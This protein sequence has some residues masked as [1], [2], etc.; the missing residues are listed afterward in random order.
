[1]MLCKHGTF[2]TILII[3]SIFLPLIFNLNAYAQGVAWVQEED[4]SSDK[5]EV[6]A[7]T[8]DDTYIYITGTDG[9]NGEVDQQWRTEKRNK[10]DGGV[11]WAVTRNF[12]G[13]VE[14]PMSIA[15]DDD[16]VYICGN[17]SYDGKVEKRRKSD[18]GLIWTRSDDT[19]NPCNFW[20]TA[21]AV[22][23]DYIYYIGYD[24]D[25]SNSL[26]YVY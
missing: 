1:M 11:V 22:S 16:Y 20:H 15:S 5:D 12:S 21:I 25:D 9:T 6:F 19:N 4:I 26:D 23:G 7:I 2:I 24:T 10:S 3:I 14:R 13:D 8:S 18:G 17:G